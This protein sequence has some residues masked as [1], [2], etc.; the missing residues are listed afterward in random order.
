MMGFEDVGAWRRKVESALVRRHRGQLQTVLAL[1]KFS[2]KKNHI[3]I[4]II[5][6]LTNTKA[7]KQQVLKSVNFE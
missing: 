2:G 7:V 4:Y 6:M 1:L 5:N 3:Y